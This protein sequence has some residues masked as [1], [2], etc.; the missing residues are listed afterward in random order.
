MANS[1]QS[2]TKRTGLALGWSYAGTA[3]R[4][5]LSLGINILLA[6]LVGPGAYGQ[7]A[8]AGIPI[9]LGQLI[10]NVGLATALIQR[11]KLTEEDIRFCFTAQIVLAVL[12]SGTLIL[13]ASQWAAFFREP[14]TIPLFRWFS[15]YFIF[16]A[17]GSTSMALL[18]REQDARTL[19]IA[20]I[21]SYVVGYIG[22]GVT[23]AWKG[24]GVWSLIAA[25]L[26]QSLV[27]SVVVYVKVGHSIVPTFHPRHYH[28]LSFGARVLGANIANWS[29]SSMDN[30]FVG[31]YQGATM[32]G[33]Y[34]RAFSLAATPSEAIVGN[35]TGVLLPPMSRVQ[36]DLKKLQDI[37]AG[38]MGLLTLVVG[39]IFVGGAVAASSVIVGLYGQRWVGAIPLFRP[40]ALAIPLQA[41][42]AICGPV[43]AARGKPQRELQMQVFTAL[44]ALVAFRFAALHNVVLLAWVVLLTALIRYLLMS[45]AVL[46]ELNGRWSDLAGACWPSIVVSVV[47]GSAAFGIELVTTNVAP[48]LRLVLVILGTGVAYLTVLALFGRALLTP[49]LTRMPQMSTLLPGRLRTWLVVA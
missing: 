34:S 39:P 44:F 26:V 35:F 17:I 49:I 23:M 5:V 27:A 46:R 1:T 28:F 47:S 43:L 8:I 15:L 25:M 9:G 37:F 10:C 18:N 6:R 11:E 36:A 14:A 16:Q 21:A 3:T 41:A 42:M 22:V 30:M 13:S 29:I 32:L 19:Q 48:L 20:N 2:L 40:L 4:I 12:L 7:L 24:Y 45:S 33:L 31:R 38:V